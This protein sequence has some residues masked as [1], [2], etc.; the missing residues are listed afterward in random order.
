MDKLCS[1]F[2]RGIHLRRYLGFMVVS[3]AVTMVAFNLVCDS[4]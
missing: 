3:L 1:T 4:R 2:L